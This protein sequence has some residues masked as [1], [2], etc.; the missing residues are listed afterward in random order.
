[1]HFKRVLVLCSLLLSIHLQSFAGEWID[2][3]ETEPLRP[4][5]SVKLTELQSNILKEQGLEQAKEILGLYL[6]NKGKRAA[7]PVTG[8]YK[9]RGKRLYYQP[10][11]TLGYG[12]TFT[13]VYHYRDGILKSEK[14]STPSS[15][16]SQES[17]VVECA[18]PL[19]DTIPYNTLYFHIRFS[20]PMLEDKYA[21]KH[22]KMLDEHG[23]ERERAW[24]QKSFWLDGG[25]L[26]VLM[27]HPGRVKNGIHYESPLFDSGKYYMLKVEATIKDA[28][29]NGI[30]AP[31]TQKFFVKGEDRAI[32]QLNKYQL[33]Q[34]SANTRQPIVLSFSEGM[35]N[36]SVLDGVS[37]VNEKGNIVV[38]SIREYVTDGVYQI[39]P[40]EKWRKGNYTLVIEGDVY[41]FAGNRMNRPFE[42]KNAKEIEKDKIEQKWNFEVR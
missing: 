37:V 9:I 15:P 42:I 13:A 32:P 5:L 16:R 12:L 7:L 8:N 41:D 21:Y 2:I 17:V 11:Y 33:K 20:Q 40:K 39:T 18:Y 35:D 31:Y 23:V 30:S 22:I 4:V 1:M 24:R 25:K 27:I 6:V 14:Y 34:S 19:A 3:D 38:C 28:L 10:K 26:L 36:A 29:G